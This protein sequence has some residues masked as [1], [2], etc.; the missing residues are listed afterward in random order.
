MR[1]PSAPAAKSPVCAYGVSLLIWGQ[2]MRSKLRALIRL[3]TPAACTS[4]IDSDAKMFTFGR[5]VDYGRKRCRDGDWSPGGCAVG[6]APNPSDLDS[7]WYGRWSDGT[8]VPD[9]L[10][11]LASFTRCRRSASSSAQTGWQTN[12]DRVTLRS[13]AQRSATFRNTRGLL[14]RSIER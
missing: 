8:F 12:D 9:P 5:V 14:P 3:A 1:C 4:S 2:T 10:P 7:C 13:L 11:S 6:Q